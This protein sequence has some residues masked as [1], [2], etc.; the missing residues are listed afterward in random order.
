MGAGEMPSIAFD[1]QQILD[2]APQYSK[3]PT[4][5]MRE[6]AAAGADQGYGK[7]TM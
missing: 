5:A 2:L 3:D 1:L 6:R 7:V 4:P